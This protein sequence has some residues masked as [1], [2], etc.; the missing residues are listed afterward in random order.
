MRALIATEKPF[1][2]AARDALS[3]ILK[4]AGHEVVLLESYT[5]KSDLLKAVADANALVVRSDKVTAEVLDAAPEL[6]IVVRG[7]AG[8][9]NIDCAKA[10]EKGVV[11]EN[12][13]GQNSNGVAELAFGMM[14]MLARN[15]YDGKPGTELKG[16]TLCLHAFGYAAQAVAAIAKGFQMKVYAYDPFIEASFMADKGVTSCSSVQELYSLGD[17]ISIHIPAIPE[18][19]KSINYDLL[20]N[21]KQKATL[22]N[23]ARKEVINEEDLVRYLADHQ[24]FRYGADIAPDEI[25]KKDLLDKY[26]TRVFFTPKKMAAQTVEANFNAACAAG[27]QI[28]A[29]FESGDTTFQVNK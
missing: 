25:I 4:K 27:N 6:K 15:N 24:G 3:D 20:S 13:P 12:T 1:A 22:I 7:G 10:K 16:K 17:Y 21:L 28:V 9:D 29:F 26:P 8:Y 14:I 5:E 18:T 11:V 2:P 19:I 23:T